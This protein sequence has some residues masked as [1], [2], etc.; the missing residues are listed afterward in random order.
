MQCCMCYY[1]FDID[2]IWNLHMILY[3]LIIDNLAL[4]DI[5]TGHQIN[6]YRLSN[7]LLC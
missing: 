7:V 6:P 1:K 4:L 2:K 5:G 3:K